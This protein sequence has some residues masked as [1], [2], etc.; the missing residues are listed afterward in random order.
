MRRRNCWVLQP[1]PVN[2]CPF[3]DRYKY[4]AVA[5]YERGEIGDSDLAHYLRCDIVDGPRDRARRP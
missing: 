3:P 4:L 1:Q 5:A 2:D